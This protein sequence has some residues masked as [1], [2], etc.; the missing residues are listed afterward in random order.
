[1]LSAEKRWAHRLQA[2]TM[3]CVVREC[4]RLRQTERASSFVNTQLDSWI[5]WRSG[6]PGAGISLYV[7]AGGGRRVQSCSYHHYLWEMCTISEALTTETKSV[8]KVF[9]REAATLGPH[10]GSDCSERLDKIFGKLISLIH[11]PLTRTTIPSR[12]HAG[13]TSRL[14]SL[15][16][17]P[18]Y[19]SPTNVSI[20][21]GSHFSA[22][23]TATRTLGPSNSHLIIT[24]RRD[25]S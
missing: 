20:S 17:I 12:S 7:G 18:T 24:H 5:G 3:P 11:L 21:L 10:E 4:T 2:L 13:S 15:Y 14:P 8:F 23:P 16:P 9:C 25:Y 6:A 22:I 1:M 19:Y